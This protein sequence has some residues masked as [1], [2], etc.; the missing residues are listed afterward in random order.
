M[1]AWGQNNIRSYSYWFDNDIPG[2]VTTLI[3][4]APQYTFD[5][6]IATDGISV[7]IHSFNIQFIDDS[8]N[9]SGVFSSFFFK[10]PF[11]DSGQKEIVEISHW[12]DNDLEGMT[13]ALVGPAQQLL[14]NSDLDVT[15]LS[16]GIHSLNVR[17]KDNSGICSSPMS[18]FFFKTPESESQTKEIVEISY[19]FDNNIS[20]MISE[21]IG[22]AEQLLITTDLETADLSTGI[23]S[24][25]VRFKDNAGMW[26]SPESQF[27]F[28]A[29][30]LGSENREVVGF[31][32]WVD[33][34]SNNA[35]F[36]AVGPT[37]IFF[38]SDIVDLDTLNSGFHMI[39]AQF[40]DNS[41]LWSSIVSSSFYKPLVNSIDENLVT[42]CKYW[43]DE[44]VT[45]VEEIVFTEPVNPQTLFMDIDMTYIWK[46]EHRL[47][48]QI[49]DSLNLWGTVTTD[50]VVKNPLPIA[51][52]TCDTSICFGDTIYFT[53]TSIDGDSF[54]WDFGDGTNTSDSIPEFHV[55]DE[56]GTYTISLT[57]TDIGSG[58]DSTSTQIVNVYE[59]PSP[60]LTLSGEPEFCEGESV[61][62]SA[63]PGMLYLWSTG[64]TSQT[65]TVNTSGSYS[66]TIYNTSNT[67]C[68]VQSET[69]V[70]TVINVDTTVMDATI[71]DGEVYNFGTQII[72]EPGD[73][74]EIFTAITGCDSVVNLTLNVTVIDTSVTVN[75]PTLT[76]NLDNAVYQ[77]VDCSN[78][79]SAISGANEQSF[80][81]L[82][83]GSYAVVLE[84][85]FCTDT[86][87]CYNVDLT[88]LEQT[89]EHQLFLASPNPTSGMVNLQL[90]EY[91]E[92]SIIDVLGY[93][94]FEAVLPNGR[95]VI[96]LADNPKGIYF[97]VCTGQT[98]T[99]LI[100]IIKDK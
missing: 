44:D 71:C 21:P 50:T 10:A 84:M 11:T 1:A 12:Y 90:A 6:S 61:D 14:I 13:S 67:A 31:K 79:Y 69:V 18:Q 99:R 19:W 62:I 8:A 24:V 65:I 27:F 5:A 48:F 74:T 3:N 92:V 20:G 23:H 89:L 26:S 42:A 86:S 53:N 85:D 17:F 60:G 57:V 52:F 40:L 64:E 15:G 46:G 94:I 95:H 93:K 54:F 55:Y 36:Q 75:F 33:N 80:T 38:L 28:K 98:Q 16:T 49:R 25:S 4:P 22:P 72:T 70:I 100:K 29:P 34:A 91:A 9:S 66:A 76:A 78:G 63:M 82:I 45:A 39:H 51:I 56:A 47:H 58:L 30:A 68:W 32:Y 81:P 59:I 37:Q 73:Y 96:N 7:G 43:F 97:I 77:W 83:S 41:K 35:N 88:G 2:T 87:S